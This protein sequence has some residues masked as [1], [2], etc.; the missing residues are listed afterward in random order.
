MVKQFFPHVY[1]SRYYDGL[2]HQISPLVSI[3]CVISLLWHNEIPFNIAWVSS[4]CRLIDK[5][6]KGKA[7]CASC[8]TW[9][10][11][12]VAGTKDNP[13]KS[14]AFVYQIP[15]RLQDNHTYAHD[16]HTPTLVPPGPLLSLFI[17]QR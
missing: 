17:T 6:R 7:Q 15:H 2:T 1:Q 12:V 11:A 13:T 16:A 10:A 14:M 3:R 5:A 4:R 9:T 8:G